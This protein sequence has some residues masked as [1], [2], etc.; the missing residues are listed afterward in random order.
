MSDERTDQLALAGLLHDIGKFMLRATVSGNRTWDQEAKG[1]FGYKHAMLT[2]TF[3][4]QYVPEPWRKQVKN[5]A[6][7][8]HRPHSREDCIVS[9]ADILS[10]AERDD[11]TDDENPRTVHPQQLLSIFSVLTADGIKPDEEQRRYLP[12]RPLALKEDV[13]F[14]KEREKS[15]QVWRAYEDMWL[16]FEQELKQL[17]EAHNQESDLR[18]YLESLLLLTQRYLWCVPSAY[19]KNLPDISLYDHGRTTA[20]LAAALHRDTVD[21]A[22]LNRWRKS[23]ETINDQIALLIGGD[24]SGVQEFIYTITARGAAPTLR[25]RSFYLQILTDALARYILQQL[26]LPITNLIY[27]G[28]GSFFLLAS[29]DHA[30]KLPQIQ[31]EISRILLQQ[32]GIDLYVALAHV[33]LLGKDFF[34]KAMSRKWKDVHEALRQQKLRRFAEIDDDE[35]AQKLFEPAGHGG[36]EDQLCH[37]CGQEHP[38]TV[39]QEQPDADPVQKCPSCQAFEDLGDELRNARYLMLDEITQK[40]LEKTQPAGTW[41]DTLAHLGMKVQL[42]SDRVSETANGSRRVLLSLD[43]EALS[44]LR[45]SVH[46]SIGRRFLVNVAP[47]LQADELEKLRNSMTPLEKAELP[48]QGVKSFSVLAHQSNGIKRLGILRMDVDNLGT[49]FQHGFGERATLSRMAALSFAISLYFEGWVSQVVEKVNQQRDEGRIYTIYSGGDDLFFVGSWDVMVELAIHIRADLTPYAADHPGIHASAGIALVSSKYP[50]AQAA[51]EA[52]QAEKAAKNLIWWDKEGDT[53]QK[54]AISFLDE[55]LPWQ[56]FGRETDCSRNLDTAHGLLHTLLEAMNKS[57][58]QAAPRT[59]IRT[60]INFH[61]QYRSEQKQWQQEHGRL[62]RS[63]QEQMFWGP[64]IWRAA[65]AFKRRTS[66]AGARDIEGTLRDIEGALRHSNYR[67]MEWLG[68]AARWAD[69]YRRE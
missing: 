12:L 49:L 9:L 46:T 22:T 53:R 50:L 63:G 43:D 59:F 37:V 24:I 17:K 48:E 14:P 11:G 65:Y 36:N 25:G 66:M 32:H 1:D 23:P 2:A 56:K 33:P 7:N 34:G 26:D 20:A 47:V 60:L 41:H 69:L 6:G 15:D 18:A 64:W 58:D 38:E 8:H 31:Q 68:V 16:E 3:V 54:D 4:D 61:S 51:Q 62:N 28:G 13:L 35:L 27:A 40:P 57:K 44:S 42:S 21:K 45:P 29:P 19:Y 55:P 30:Q 39:A 10:A 52:A 67:M 5:M